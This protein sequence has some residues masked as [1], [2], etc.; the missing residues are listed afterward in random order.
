MLAE[1]PK[2]TMTN[3]QY[4]RSRGTHRK[5]KRNLQAWYEMNKEAIDARR[6][7]RAKYGKS[8]WADKD[9]YYDE[10]D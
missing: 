2:G 9:Y 6:A 7:S 4:R 1:I 8:K 3:M 10:E 5:F